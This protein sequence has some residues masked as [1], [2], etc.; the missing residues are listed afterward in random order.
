ME[1]KEG[2][3]NFKDDVIKLYKEFHDLQTL[4]ESQRIVYFT[5]DPLRV[6]ENAANLEHRT[7]RFFTEAKIYFVLYSR[8]TAFPQMWSIGV[9]SHVP[10]NIIKIS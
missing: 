5:I 1:I 9:Y 6:C 10:T 7:I 2:T 3:I 4:T 8:L